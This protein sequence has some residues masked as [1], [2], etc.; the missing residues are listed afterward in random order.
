[1]SLWFL[2]LRRGRIGTLSSGLKAFDSLNKSVRTFSLFWH[3][4]FV[5]CILEAAAKVPAHSATKKSAQDSKEARVPNSSQRPNETGT[6]HTG[7]TNDG[8]ANDREP[9]EEIAENQQAATKNDSAS[10]IDKD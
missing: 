9:Q 4:V 10:E 3:V 1:M 2:W 8:G 5:G 7:D 6:T